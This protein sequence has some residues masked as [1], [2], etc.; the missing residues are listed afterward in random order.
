MTPEQV[1]SYPSRVLT[2]AQREFYFEQGYLLVEDVVPD[3]WLQR[4]QGAMAELI[5]RSRDLAES[6]SAYDLEDGHSADNP[7]LRRVTNANEAHPTFWKYISESL[8]A[9]IAADLVG[10]DVKFTDSNFNFKSAGGGTEIRWHQDAQYTPYTNYSQTTIGTMLNDVGPDQ[11][12]MAVIAGSHNGELF[13]LYGDNGVWS[14][15]ISDRDLDRVDLE[16]VVYLTGRAGTIQIHN[17]RTI[18]GSARNNSD[19]G[20]PLLLNT[21]VAADAFPYRPHAHP[22]RHLYA[23]VRGEPARWAHLDPRPNLIP[24]DWSKGRGYLSI[25]TWQQGERDASEGQLPAS[26]G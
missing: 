9:D 7:R 10:P 23:Q 22:H 4:L 17:C 24:P 12:P 20:R 18:H 21:Y 1:L 11:A 15:M 6:N 3:E 8:L 5:E 19:L 16:K 2:Q 25:F 26:Q 14:G 13:D